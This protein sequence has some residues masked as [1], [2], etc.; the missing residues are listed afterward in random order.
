MLELSDDARVT[1]GVVL[2][3]VVAVE[4][5]GVSLLR[6]LLGREAAT[7]WVLPGRGR[8]G[9][10]HAAPRVRARAR[11]R[12]GA[13]GGRRHAGGRSPA[14]VTCRSDVAATPAAGAQP[15][16]ASETTCF[17]AACTSPRCSSLTKLSA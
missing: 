14:G 6:L 9:P 7:E 11:R 3:T 8:A 15:C 13:G 17:A 2:L 1:A 12:G 5:G 16:S 4:A 10:H